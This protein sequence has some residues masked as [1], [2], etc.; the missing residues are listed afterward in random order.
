[1]TEREFSWLS[2]LERKRFIKPKT[3]TGKRKKERKRDT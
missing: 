1:M 3:G 2:G